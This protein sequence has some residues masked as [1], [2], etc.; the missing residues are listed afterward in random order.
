VSNLGPLTL[1]VVFANAVTPES[2]VGLDTDYNYLAGVILDNVAELRLT[3]PQTVA[4]GPPRVYIGGN[5]TVGDG[6]GGWYWYNPSDTGSADNG[7]T[8][9]VS[10]DGS[11][12]YLE[13][14]VG[15]GITAAEMTAGV[16]VTNY[17]YPVGDMR[18]YGIKP[19]GV[20]NTAIFA[21]VFGMFKTAGGAITFPPGDYA[22]YIDIS[23][24]T[25]AQVIVYGNGC[26]IRPY[27]SAPANSCALYCNNGGAGGYTTWASS[28]FTFR[29]V[30]FSGALYA[31]NTTPSVNYAVEFLGASA[32]FWNCQFNY[33]V[34][35]GFYCLY[36]QYNEFWACS[37][38]VNTTSAASA[39]ALCVSHGS[40]SASNEILFN[41]C[42]FFV[43]S[44]GLWL[45]GAFKPRV[46]NC[47]FQGNPAG[48][49]GVLVLD[50]DSTGLGT[51]GAEITGNWFE[52][53]QTPHIC[54]VL[55][56]GTNISA[57][58]FLSS[59]GVNQ[60]TFTHCYD[61]VMLGNEAYTTCTVTLNHPNGNTDTAT[62]TYRGNGANM[63]PTMAITHNGPCV[64]DAPL[65]VTQSPS[66][67]SITANGQTIY[68]QEGAY[69]TVR[70][71]P[72]AAYTG[73]ILQAGQFSGQ[74]CIVINESAAA[75]TLTMAA[76]GTSN[77][78]DGASCVLAGLRQMA[79]AWDSATSLWY[80][81]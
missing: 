48:G 38:N 30:V 7:S 75:N 51:V 15:Q 46:M 17:S 28:N 73:I 29:D 71:A 44:V 34:I 45:K 62:V 12:W 80:H 6:G 55:A 59:G 22:G 21:A 31:A 64:V 13:P 61:L 36:G 67:Q 25:N 10:A 68:S 54:E 9:I 33:G 58:L 72:T 11:R 5:L 40:G 63:A 2:S 8:I 50:Q 16:T 60:I 49:Q 81:T 27:T 70:V 20:D 47:T 14:V 43:N 66:V 18:R 56:Q 65:S 3:T 4:S 41:R 79:F 24:A 26:T 57:N 78:A 77:V 42:Q 53:N 37:F 35:A 39:G 1:P 19:N 69:I 76:A 32:V 52:D 74:Q 23:G